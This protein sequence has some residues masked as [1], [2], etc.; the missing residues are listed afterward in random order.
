MNFKVVVTKNPSPN[1]KTNEWYL[2]CA[3][4]PSSLIFTFDIAG[5]T[6]DTVTLSSIEIKDP[7]YQGLDNKI[8]TWDLAANKYHSLEVSYTGKTLSD[9]PS[10][11]A[12]PIH[13]FFNVPATLQP[14]MRAR[15]FDAASK[16]ADEYTRSFMSR[17]NM[18]IYLDI[19]EGKINAYVIHCELDDP[20]VDDSSS[21]AS[22]DMR[23]SL[24][25]RL[26]EHIGKLRLKEGESPYEE[27]DVIDLQ[28]LDEIEI[29]NSRYHRK[30]IATALVRLAIEDLGLNAIGCERH[31]MGE[32]T[33]EFSLTEY[34]EALIASCI[35]KGIVTGN[36]CYHVQPSSRIS[37]LLEVDVEASDDGYFS[38][39]V[40]FVRPGQI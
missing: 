27:E 24:E 11:S 17:I 2:T 8:L 23:S 33:A 39:G 35:D 30:G 5:T 9:L 3:N 40:E 7:I 15:C 6:Q 19:S 31:V 14:G 25:L 37:W 22:H 12:R 26:G 29:S 18:P 1:N 10:H 16:I 28:W 38:E 20:I 34:G 4:L 21:S 32:T 36:M 13:S